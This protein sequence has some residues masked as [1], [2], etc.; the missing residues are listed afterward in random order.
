MSGLQGS[1]TQSWCSPTKGNRVQ[2]PSFW[3]VHSNLTKFGT[4]H[5][6]KKHVLHS[7]IPPQVR[8]GTP[9]PPPQKKKKKNLWILNILSN[10]MTQQLNFSTWPNEVRSILL[11]DTSCQLTVGVGLRGHKMCEPT[12]SI[13]F[14]IYKHSKRDLLVVDLFVLLSI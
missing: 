11:Q 1:V 6:G 8:G 4:T 7:S 14:D 13:L 10:C 9:A 12:T 3:D 5:L 2:A